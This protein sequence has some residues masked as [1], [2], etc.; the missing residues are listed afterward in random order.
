V[1][2]ALLALPALLLLL[3]L[4]L[5]QL[6]PAAAEVAAGVTMLGLCLLLLLLQAAAGVQVLPHACKLT[7]GLRTLP[8]TCNCSLQRCPA[9]HMVAQSAHNVVKTVTKC[10]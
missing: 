8:A 6:P 5:G 3:L 4:P 1:C 9:Y 10:K 7:G 2:C